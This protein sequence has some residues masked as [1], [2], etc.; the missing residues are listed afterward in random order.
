MTVAIALPDLT[1]DDDQAMLVA[2]LRGKIR[3]FAKKNKVKED[4]YEAK[5]KIKHLDI[6]VPPHLRDLLDVS[7][8]WPGTA[9][10]VLEERLDWL[11]WTSLNDMMGLDE[12]FR[13]NQLAIEGG[14]AHLDALIT[15]TDFVSVGKGDPNSDEP[16]VMVA[17]ESASSA[18]MQ[19]NYRRRRAD[20]A[21]SQTRDAAGQ[22]ILESL[23][24][25]D[26]TILFERNPRSR[27]LEAVDRDTHGL[28]RV[29]MSRFVNRDRASD[30]EGRSEITRPV[31][32][33]T[34]AALRT[35][36][37]MEINREFYTAPQW[38]AL[39]AYPEQFG[40]D[41]NSSP[42]A[43]K[44]AGWKN[45][46]GRMNIVPPNED[47]EGPEV[48]IQQ[49]TP[50]PP[51]PYIDQMKAYS[52]L[53]SAETGIPSSYLGFVTDNPPSADSI[54]QLEYRLVKRAERRQVTFG[55][56]WRE[57]AYL[58]L[59]VRDGTVDRDK[60]REIDVKWRDASTP[61]RAAS[62]DEALKLVSSEILL[63]DSEI[64]YD[65][66]GLSQQDQAK[67]TEE[68]RRARAADLPG[69]LREAASQV[70]DPSV[71]NLAS[72]RVSE[73]GNADT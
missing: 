35:L 69:R 37:G 1:L 29:L 28:G 60:F 38:F 50:S 34:D 64:T 46:M 65:R 53:V 13:D 49:T 58:S 39:N 33:Y 52:Q 22:V 14:R 47:G 15:G 59:L 8:G 62:A 57:V 54:R 72:R 26:E 44:A 68:K 41:E 63:P 27:K 61:T 30:L 4:Y 21:L 9:V 71:V 45:T 56:G 18:T 40:V 32:Y 11:G 43:K 73:D 67:I 31:R 36:L 10:D 17:I 5:Q 7:M 19:W 6:A 12:I 66:I 42:E 51:T 23:Y 24:L 20:A 16:E 3:K 70:T 25:P 2:F 55:V 48:K